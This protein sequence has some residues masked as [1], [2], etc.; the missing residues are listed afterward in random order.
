MHNDNTVDNSEKKKQ[1]ITYFSNETK[2][3]ANTVH[4]MKGSYSI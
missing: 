2:G 1:E 3:K 4:E